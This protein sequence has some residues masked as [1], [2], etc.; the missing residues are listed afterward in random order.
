MPNY[1]VDV[2][3]VQQWAKRYIVTAENADEV[4]AMM[5]GR[6]VA[7]VIDIVAENLQGTTEV[8]IENITP[9]V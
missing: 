3:E 6:K 7:K 5:E 1:A 8:I 4:R 2:I 9:S